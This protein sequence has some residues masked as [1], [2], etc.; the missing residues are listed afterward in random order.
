MSYVLDALRKVEMERDLSRV[1]G[2]ASVQP[3]VAQRRRSRIPVVLLVL[4]ALLLGAALAWLWANRDVLTADAPI[5]ATPTEGSSAPRG[6]VGARQVEHAGA[7]S[8][9]ARAH[10]SEPAM[11]RPAASAG[12]S[13]AI[14]GISP[15]PRPDAWSESWPDSSAD[16][17]PARGDG[18]GDTGP[19]SPA[20]AP[21]RLRVKTAGAAAVEPAKEGAAQVRGAREALRMAMVESVLAPAASPG[22]PVESTIATPPASSPRQHDTPAGADQPL[23]TQRVAAGAEDASDD[24]PPFLR[25][26]PYLFQKTLPELVI[27]AQVYS[28]SAESR[29]VIL[30]M[31]RYAEGQRTR[32]GVLVERIETDS[33]VL[34][35]QGQRFRVRR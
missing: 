20:H 15:D 2:V 23:G 34:Q 8:L 21:E 26:L 11:A 24:A 22:I 25:T 14:P 18:R 33:L 16:S 6:A 32:E 31:K 1:P 28:E 27:N 17:L 4:A 19:S 5:A 12:E 9:P 7:A 10:P 35:Y 29:F 3:F 30:N 13:G